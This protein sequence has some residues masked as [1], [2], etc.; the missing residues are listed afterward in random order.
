MNVYSGDTLIKK[1]EGTKGLCT[2]KGDKTDN[3]VAGFLASIGLETNQT[4]QTSCALEASGWDF[5]T[6]KT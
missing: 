4:A 2:L 6:P 1:L 3:P 5:L